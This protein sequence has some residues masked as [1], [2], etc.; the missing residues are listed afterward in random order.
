MT[1]QLCMCKL[2]HIWLAGV[3]LTRISS[4]CFDWSVMHVLTSTCLVDR[5]ELAIPAVTGQSCMF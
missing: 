4:T 1:G 2:L 3:C 5:K